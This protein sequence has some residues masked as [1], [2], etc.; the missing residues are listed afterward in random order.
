MYNPDQRVELCQRLVAFRESGG[1]VLPK[2]LADYV[3][4][5][6]SLGSEGLT[7]LF[8][9]VAELHAQERRFLA[10]LEYAGERVFRLDA[11]MR[12]RVFYDALTG[13][14]LGA[15]TRLTEEELRGLE[16]RRNEQKNR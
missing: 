12:Q 7:L 4:S 6:G 16:V 10:D 11:G 9:P 1:A 2:D 3:S 8:H 13:R 15:V 14:S 5:G